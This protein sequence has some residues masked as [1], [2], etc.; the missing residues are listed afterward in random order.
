MTNRRHW[1]N[2]RAG[3]ALTSQAQGTAYSNIRILETGHLVKAP[4]DGAA[5]LNM[6]TGSYTVG[7]GTVRGNGQRQRRTARLGSD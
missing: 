7:D 3:D 6:A 4:S 1:K 5:I 2:K